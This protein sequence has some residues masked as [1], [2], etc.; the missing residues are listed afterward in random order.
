MIKDFRSY[1]AKVDV[2]DL[3]LNLEEAEL[4]YGI[5]T[6]QTLEQGNSDLIILT[7]SHGQFRAIGIKKIPVLGERNHANFDVN[8]IFPA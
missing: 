7:V 2:Y 5:E 4:E 6:V 3:W 1:H 8:Y